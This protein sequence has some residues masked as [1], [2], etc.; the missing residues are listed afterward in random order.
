MRER[1]IKDGNAIVF[2]AA[3]EVL[4]SR[5]KKDKVLM[6]MRGGPISYTTEE[7]VKFWAKHP[8]QWVSQEEADILQGLSNPEFRPVSKEVVEDYYAY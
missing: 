5:G 6:E 3:K 2:D 1:R 8:Y 4:D 7:G